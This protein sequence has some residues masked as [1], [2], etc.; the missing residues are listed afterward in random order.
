MSFPASLPFKWCRLN[1]SLHRYALQ[2][3]RL[4]L[5]CPYPPSLPHPAN[6]LAV[7]TTNGIFQLKTE[8]FAGN[9]EGVK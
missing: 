4:P 3:L 8:F 5:A 9:S 6:G 7:E 2:R 1:A